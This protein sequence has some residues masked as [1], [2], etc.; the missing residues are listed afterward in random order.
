MN[1]IPSVRATEPGRAQLV[2]LGVSPRIVVLISV[3]SDGPG[4]SLF[5]K[6]HHRG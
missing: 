2:N 6:K 5:G 1:M 4:V 3:A